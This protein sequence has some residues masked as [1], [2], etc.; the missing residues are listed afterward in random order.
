MRRTFQDFDITSMGVE[1]P[2]LDDEVYIDISNGSGLIAGV[3]FK[4]APWDTVS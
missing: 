4:R 1:N 2:E 3:N